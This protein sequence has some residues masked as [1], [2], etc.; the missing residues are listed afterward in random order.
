MI[1]WWM[2]LESIRLFERWDSVWQECT[3]VTSY[4][5]QLD[6]SRD[7]LWHIDVLMTA[8]LKESLIIS[9]LPTL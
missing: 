8:S 1:G 9:E 4:A 7:A 5:K 3:T 6:Q 2:A